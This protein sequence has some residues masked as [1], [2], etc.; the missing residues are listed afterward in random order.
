M[1]DVDVT[2]VRETLAMLRTVD[3]ALWRQAVAELKAPAKVMAAGIRANLPKEAPLK[4]FDHSGRTGWRSSRPSVTVKMSGSTAPRKR[5]APLLSIR[6]AGAALS[7]AD[8]AGRGPHGGQLAQALDR[9]GPPSRWVWPAANRYA[10]DVVAGVEK[11]AK[12][13]QADYTRSMAYR[14]R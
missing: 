4:G 6:A 11:A 7:I 9:Y 5:R 2:G 13:V 14:G 10:R 12:Q 3:R 1:A 8:L